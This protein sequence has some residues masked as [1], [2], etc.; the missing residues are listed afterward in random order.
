M[1]GAAQTTISEKSRLVRPLRGGQITIPAEFR[2][3]LGLDE[4]SL[5]R[6]TL[7]GG[8]LRLQH[9]FVDGLLFRREAA[10]DRERTRDVRRIVLVLTTG[11][12]QQQVAVLQ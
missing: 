8:E 5:L 10:I 6:V 2:K 7:D 9:Q 3:Q 1:A 11:I 12:D 4:S